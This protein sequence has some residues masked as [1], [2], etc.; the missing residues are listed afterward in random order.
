MV[1]VTFF[2]S[3]VKS[4][5]DAVQLRYAWSPDSGAVI[6]VPNW[7]EIKF[8]EPV[9]VGGFTSRRVEL[10]QGEIEVKIRNNKPAEN[11]FGI[12]AGWLGVTASRT[13]FWVSQS[14]DKKV[15]VIGVYEGEVE[16]KTKD[17]RT[18]KVKTDTDKPGVA[19]V[20]QKLSPVKLAIAGLVLVLIIG[21][22]VLILKRK[23][24]SIV[25]GKKRS[26]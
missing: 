23:F 18:V 8:R 25:T 14:E 10:G 9:E 5:S 15:A 3:T 4:T 2:D 6:N 19:V 22:T 26:K 7:S 21:G 12:D 11:Q 24:A 17:G 16:V 20:S 13:H 1:T